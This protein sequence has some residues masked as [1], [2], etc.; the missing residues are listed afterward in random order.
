MNNIAIFDALNTIHWAYTK[1]L[2]TSTDVAYMLDELDI[3][4]DT[5]TITESYYEFV[6]LDGKTKYEKHF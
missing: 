1:K 4:Y 5:S 6:S 3:N 2:I